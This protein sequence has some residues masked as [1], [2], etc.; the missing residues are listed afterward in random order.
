MASPL[1]KI[2]VN[3]EEVHALSVDLLEFLEDSQHTVGT[4]LM[5]LLMTTGR[6]MSPTMLDEEKE[7]EFLQ[8]A[9]EFCGLYFTDNGRPN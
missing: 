8:A 3:V 4:G 1:T 2:S 9:M 6:L 5:A 7:F